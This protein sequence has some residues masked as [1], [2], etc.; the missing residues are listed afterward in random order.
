MFLNQSLNNPSSITM[1][2]PECPR[3]LMDLQIDNFLDEET[4]H[5]VLEVVRSPIIAV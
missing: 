3:L 5:Q 1:T 2:V 4:V